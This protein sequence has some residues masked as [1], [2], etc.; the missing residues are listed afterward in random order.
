MSH[1]RRSQT[2][3]RANPRRR[4]HIRVLR[5]WLRRRH[6]RVDR[7]WAALNGCLRARIGMGP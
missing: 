2:R 4:I 5:L 1:R 3:R 6:S 7:V